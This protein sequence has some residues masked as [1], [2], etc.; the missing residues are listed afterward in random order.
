MA[1]INAN[2]DGA[3]TF[4]P[5][6]GPLLLVEDELTLRR[7]IRRNLERRGIGITE[8]GTL[9]E[10]LASAGKARPSLLVL[11]INLPDGSGWELLHQL[12]ATGSIPPTIVISAGRVAR[13][14]LHE[15][16]IAAFLPKPF[17]IEALLRQVSALLAAERV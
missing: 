7:T 13:D 16:G 6:Y 9:R 14:R 12:R 2:A 4:A 17:R 10:G 15:F 3:R 11:D 1:I 5:R 8:A